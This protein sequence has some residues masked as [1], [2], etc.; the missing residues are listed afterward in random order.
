MST[1]HSKILPHTIST[2]VLTQH[3]TTS[4]YLAFAATVSLGY[5]ISQLSP[6]AAVSRV[7][8]SDSAEL[9][10]RLRQPSHMVSWPFE[11]RLPAQVTCH[12]RG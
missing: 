5:G 1:L 12:D 2:S 6:L 7:S 3:Y 9:G 8:Q 11:W 4:H 10:G